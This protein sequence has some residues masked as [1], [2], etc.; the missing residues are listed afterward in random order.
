VGRQEWV[1]GWGSTLIEAGERV[2]GKG[3]LE[4]RPGKGITFERRNISNE[5]DTERGRDRERERE[6]ERERNTNL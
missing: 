5:R 4:G 2:W 1:G 3:F 6:R